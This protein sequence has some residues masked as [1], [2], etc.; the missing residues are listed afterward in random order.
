MTELQRRHV[1]QAHLIEAPDVP[2][3]GR[4]IFVGMDAGVVALL[5]P[6]AAIVTGGMVKVAKV[7]GIFPT[8]QSG[9]RSSRS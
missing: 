1:H 4:S 9:W 5:I 2:R 8:E 6:I 7:R 3:T